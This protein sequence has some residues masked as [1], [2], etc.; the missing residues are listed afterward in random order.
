[1]INHLRSPSLDFSR[2]VSIHSIRRSP[3]ICASLSEEAGPRGDQCYRWEEKAKVALRVEV[4]E[5]T[6]ESVSKD[7]IVSNAHWSDYCRSQVTGYLEKNIYPRLGT[8]PIATIRA[9]DPSSDNQECRCSR[10]K[11]RRDPD[12][13]AVRTDLLLCRSPRALHL[14]ILRHCSRTW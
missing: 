4:N 3:S 5:H 8:L 9:P 12:S 10:Y 14:L 1:M 2:G 13:P 7:G 6:V 11:D